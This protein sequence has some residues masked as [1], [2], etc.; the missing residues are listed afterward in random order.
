[1]KSK[2]GTEQK[3][4]FSNISIHRI[5]PVLVPFAVHISV[6]CLYSTNAV[7][8]LSIRETRPTTCELCFAW[9][10]RTAMPSCVVFDNA[11]EAFLWLS[12]LRTSFSVPALPTVVV[13][14]RKAEMLFKR[15]DGK[16]SGYPVSECEHSDRF[17]MSERATHRRKMNRSC[18]CLGADRHSNLQMKKWAY[19]CQHVKLIHHFQVVR[20]G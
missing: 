17:R 6:V 18:V 2:F 10:F 13:V 5:L 8:F 11:V 7:P 9:I 1:M 16:P 4:E 12:R 20:R 15:L 19:F 14:K 3:G